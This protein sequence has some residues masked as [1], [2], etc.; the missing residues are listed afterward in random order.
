MNNLKFERWQ[1]KF[2]IF[3]SYENAIFYY[4]AFYV[5][6]KRIFYCI[7]TNNFTVLIRFSQFVNNMQL[8]TLPTTV[9]L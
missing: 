7:E 3:F 1:N 4:E 5:S 9:D 2:V 6:V 8:L